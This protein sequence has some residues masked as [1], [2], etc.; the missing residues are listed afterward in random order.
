MFVRQV[1]LAQLIPLEGGTST[2]DIP[3]Q[4]FHTGTRRGKNPPLCDFAPE[5]QTGRSY[6]AGNEKREVS[7]L[8][9]FVL[10]TFHP[11]QQLTRATGEHGGRERD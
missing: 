7:G 11:A 10:P 8:I 3:I 6:G 4:K 9:S 2:Y 1:R 5:E